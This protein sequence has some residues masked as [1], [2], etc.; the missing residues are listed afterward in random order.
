[1]RR[2]CPK[3]VGCGP[4]TLL[5]LRHLLTF[6]TWS[7][8]AHFPF[9]VFAP[10]TQVVCRLLSLAPGGRYLEVNLA[11]TW[12]PES[13]HWSIWSWSLSCPHW[14]QNALAFSDFEEEFQANQKNVRSMQPQK[15]EWLHRWEPCE[16]CTIC[17]FCLK[18]PT[19]LNLAHRDGRLPTGVHNTTWL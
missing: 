5:L 9:A 16:L 7:Q 14:G 8:Q 18:S 3:N 11:F 13:P 15:R 1:M 6:L 10:Y 4:R 2:I 17:C 12:L 19:T